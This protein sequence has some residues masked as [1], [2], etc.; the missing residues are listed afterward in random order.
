MGQAGL[1]LVRPHAENHTFDAYERLYA[2]LC[3]DGR[4]PRE[5]CAC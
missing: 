3:A 1:E 2:Q 4:P 5:E